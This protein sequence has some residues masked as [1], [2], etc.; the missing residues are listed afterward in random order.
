MIYKYILDKQKNIH[1]FS[2]KA[3][4]LCRKKL[5][6]IILLSVSFRGH[7]LTTF[8]NSD[9]LWL[10]FPGPCLW[11]SPYN[12]LGRFRG[13]KCVQ[14]ELGTSL[15]VQW[16]I[17]LHISNVGGLGLILGPGTRSHITTTKTQS[18]PINTLGIPGGS[19]LKNLLASAGDSRQETWV[20]WGRFP[21]GGNGNPLQYFCQE[22]PMDR[23]A[24]WAQPVGSQ[25]VRHGWVSTRRAPTD[26]V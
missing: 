2:L 18:S 10:Q 14:R 17:R 8:F 20:W 5:Y 15:V 21:G 13:F 26:S 11:V 9:A 6:P 19:M 23:G 3:P 12:L 16:L 24:W 4:L 7:I 22:N 25:R 1:K